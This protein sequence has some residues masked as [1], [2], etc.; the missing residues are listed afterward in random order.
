M[1]NAM[2]NSNRQ[3]PNTPTADGF[4][5]SHPSPRR[6]GDAAMR[7]PLTPAVRPLPQPT[8]SA[9]S[10]QDT[11]SVPGLRIVTPIRRWLRSR[12]TGQTT[13]TPASVNNIGTDTLAGSPTIPPRPVANAGNNASVVTPPR[14]RRRVERVWPEIGTMLTATY[15]GVVY[16]AQVVQAWKRLT[17]GKQILILT[18][19]AAGRRAD[20][21]S[22]AMLKATSRQRRENKLG[23]KG[24]CSGWSFWKQVPPVLTSS[25]DARPS[26]CSV[27]PCPLYH[28]NA[29]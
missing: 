6:M 7:A 10:A 1:E 9:T 4:H 25:P 26:A 28:K 3:Y 23:V 18:G 21:F 8:A 13:P 27:Q 2:L 5:Q 20:S 15:F 19:S 24:L 12:G 11:P 14:K 22:R 16:R 17:S 29:G